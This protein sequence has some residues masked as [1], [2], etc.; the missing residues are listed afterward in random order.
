M[1]PKGCNLD[2]IDAQIADGILTIAVA[3]ITEK[4]QS[5]KIEIAVN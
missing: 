1:L 2:E 5:K 4:K 3:K